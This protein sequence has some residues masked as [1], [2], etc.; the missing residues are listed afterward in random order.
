MGAGMSL[1]TDHANFFKVYDVTGKSDSD[2]MDS[3]GNIVVANVQKNGTDITSDCTIENITG[4]ELDGMT[5]D[6]K[7]KPAYLITVPDGKHVIV[8]YWATFEG[9]EDEAVTISNK[10]SFFYSNA[11]Q[12]GGGD[13]SEESVVAAASSSTVFTGP[14]F[15]LKKTDQYGNAISGVTYTLYSVALNGDQSVLTEIMTQTTANDGTSDGIAYFGHRATDTNPNTVLKK[16]TLYCLVE[17]DAPAGYTIDDTP[18]YFEFK[19]KGSELVD[20]PSDT[21][22]H[23]FV[24]GG[25][26]SFTNE[27]T[28]ASYSIPVKKTI[29]GKTVSSDLEFSFTLKQSSGGTVYTDESRATAVTADGLQTTI[30][31]SGKGTFDTLY[32]DEAGTYTF[33]MTEDELTQEAKN[34]S[35][36]KDNN[37]FTV[38]I[39]IAEGDNKDLVV[40]SASFVSADSSV[41]G[42]DLS[43]S[44]PTFNNTSHL[45]GSITLNA[46]KE[47]TNNRALPIQAGEFAFTVSVGGEVI[48]EKDDNG[49]TIL[50]A[51]SKPV[52]K[53]FYNDANG[54]IE[55]NIDIDQDDVGTQTYVIS[56]V[57]GDDSSIKYTTD[58]VRVK[59]TIEEAVDAATGKPIVQATKYEYLTDAVFTNEYQAEG[60]LELVGTKKLTGNRSTPIKAGEFNFVVKN[61]KGHQIATG[62]TKAGGA[63]E[64]TKITY[65]ASDIG[66]T[67][68]YTI[69]EVEG[70]DKSIDYTDKTQTVTVKITDAGDGK[71]NVT[72]IDTVDD[73]A[74]GLNKSYYI[75]TNVNILSWK[76]VGQNVSLSQAASTGDTETSLAAASV[77][78]A[79]EDSA[80]ATTVVTKVLLEPFVNA[81]HAAGSVTLKGTKKLT[82]NRKDP[83]K[84]NE[85]KF[86]VKEVLTDEDGNETISTNAVAIG[87]TEAGGSITFTAIP[88]TQA[89]I[90][91]THTYKITEDKGTDTTV[92]YDEATATVTVVVSDNGD[93]SLTAEPTYSKDDGVTFTNAYKATG[94]VT[95]A[96]TKELTGD[97]RSKDIT[98]GEFKFTVKEVLTDAA[99]KETLSSDTVA[100]GETLAGTT[101]TS[102]TIQ[103]TDISYTQ[104]D[105][106]THTY[107]ISE[108]A[109]TDTTID[110]T[111]DTV[112][113]TVVVRDA[114]NG[115]LTAAA[116]YDSGLIAKFVNKYHMPAP[117]GI[118]VDI[119]PYAIMIAIAA[120]LCLLLTINRRKRRSVRRR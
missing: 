3:G 68:T 19:T 43:T 80:E 25:T 41:A 61:E 18:Y 59:V 72:Q 113:A 88:Y 78:G 108:N 95:L 6:E 116:T 117:T 73:A 12:S 54:N 99:G 42:G 87:Y 17:T 8:I 105:I 64:F 9:V 49:N 96:G 35:Y 109:G 114:G 75:G 76:V 7:G 33:T 62:T 104:D 84:E 37:T 67:Y 28:P 103:F 90:G 92:T 100:T 97:D 40:E 82:G 4:R 93:G 101:S 21:T 58:R 34:K 81:Y 119:L 23:Q 60:T 85:F 55:F 31:G 69:S 52:K 111:K 14:F 39:K 89:D 115:Q 47:I 38:T 53:L 20:H 79:D 29:N 15:K 24:Q 106:G 22:L 120:C 91:T 13:K 2:L 71:L 46:K 94:S 65:D 30:K 74:S 102:A 26:Y 112:T 110:Y 45:E 98:A 86:T 48:A 51:D 32:F 77:Y 56:E 44:V 27:F 107:V 10:A 50:D 1:S 70:T 83:V 5:D 57:K 16:D 118:R 63:I 11:I 36:T 66:Q